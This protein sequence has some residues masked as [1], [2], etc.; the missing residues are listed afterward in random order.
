MEAAEALGARTNEAPA[1][2]AAQLANRYRFS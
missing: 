1:M 2:A